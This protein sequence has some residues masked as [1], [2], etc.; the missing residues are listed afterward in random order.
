[1]R[2]ACTSTETLN[3]CSER[4]FLQQLVNEVYKDDLLGQLNAIELLKDMALTP[5]G[6]NYL[7]QQGVIGKL[8]AMIVS[9]ET[10]TMT[11][12]LLPGM[13][14]VCAGFITCRSFIIFLYTYLLLHSI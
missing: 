3:R 9:A 12:F 7:E 2:V 14:K 5:V 11:G 13:I 10:D 1:M 8:Q 6:L 4:G